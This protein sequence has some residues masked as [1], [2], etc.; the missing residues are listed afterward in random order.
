L[1]IDLSRRRQTML[2]SQTF[3]LASLPGS[4]WAVG[5]GSAVLMI[6]VGALLIR[7]AIGLKRVWFEVLPDALHSH[8][9]LCGRRLPKSVLQ[10]DQAKVLTSEADFVERRLGRSNGVGLPG[11]K[12]GWFRNRQSGEKA[13]LC[14]TD[15]RKILNIPTTQGYSLYLSTDEPAEL[16]AA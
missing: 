9:P 16:L 14:V 12:V 1:R 7:M 3:A 4:A 10:L 2:G 15:L 13:L 5:I 11:Y 6:G 8:A